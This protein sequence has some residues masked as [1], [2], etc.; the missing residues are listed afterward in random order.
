MLAPPAGITAAAAAED[1]MEGAEAAARCAAAAQSVFRRA[2]TRGTLATPATKRLTSAWKA[3]KSW[4][5]VAGGRAVARSSR[6]RAAS[7]TADA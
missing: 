2:R 3:T 4:A 5:E 6:A 7:E 1:D